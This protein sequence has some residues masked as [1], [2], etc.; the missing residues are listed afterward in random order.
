[1][2]SPLTFP[3]YQANIR[4]STIGFIICSLLAHGLVFVLSYNSSFLSGKNKESIPSSTISVLLSPAAI[5]QPAPV[6]A[7]KPVQKKLPKKLISTRSSS[8]QVHQVIEQ[9]N[10]PDKRLPKPTP[11]K[12]TKPVQTPKLEASPQPS[13]SH[14]PLLF[15]EPKPLYNPK[16]RY[17]NIARRRGIEGTVTFSIQVANN[18]AVNHAFVTQSSGSSLLDKAATKAIKTWRFPASKFNAL[19]PF[20]QKIVFQLKN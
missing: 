20:K 18:G 3:A 17:P 2:G 11:V 19:A 15:S 13:S 16:P 7:N 1:M 4:A 5:K 10:K 14:K 8:R 9:K 12:Q 6:Q